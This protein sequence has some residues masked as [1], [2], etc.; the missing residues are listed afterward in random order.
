MSL[1]REEK[2]VV[3]SCTGS[4][5]IAPQRQF[6]FQNL[7]GDESGNYHCILGFKPI[8]V[9][10]SFTQPELLERQIN[11]GDN[12]VISNSKI[13]PVKLMIRSQRDGQTLPLETRQVRNHLILHD[14]NV[15]GIRAPVL[16]VV[17]YDEARC[18]GFSP[19]KQTTKIPS[20]V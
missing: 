2:Q 14:M 16:A 10:S 9:Q 7:K 13:L 19:E 15:V 11:L 12:R 6:E 18:N 5:R 4:S 3:P 17:L 1:T 20:I 8:L